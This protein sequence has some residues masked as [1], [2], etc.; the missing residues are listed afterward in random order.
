MRHADRVKLLHG[1]YNAPPL[2][3][4]DRAT[5]LARDCDVIVTGW[6]AGC[7]QWPRC[8]ALGTHGGGSGLLVEEELARAV[9][10]ESALAIRHWWGVS[11]AVVWRWRKAMGVEGRAGTEG[12]RRLIQAAAAKGGA[13]LRGR[14]LTAEEVE[15]RRRTNREL[16]LAR[17]LVKG[18]H[19]PRW[20]RKELALLGKLPDEEVAR[21]TG[22]TLNAVRAVRARRN[23]ASACDRRRKG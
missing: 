5:C 6:S 21:R 2:K 15:Q 11:V 23:N 10:C 20:T 3:R 16:D 17:H 22:R 12:S 9:R 8:R 18:Y 19:G 13:V 7:I 4:G 14:P 1:P